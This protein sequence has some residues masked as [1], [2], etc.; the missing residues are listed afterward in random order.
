MEIGND[1][2]DTIVVK[3]DEG[4]G[5]TVI[6]ANVRNTSEDLAVFQHTGK[7][8]RKGPEKRGNCHRTAYH[9]GRHKAFA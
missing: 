3:I 5:R 2:F 1:G 7:L 8:E 9:P 6:H 4:E